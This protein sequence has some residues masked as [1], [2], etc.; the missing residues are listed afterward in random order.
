[1]YSN[2]QIENRKIGEMKN[3]LIRIER[4]IRGKK[5]QEVRF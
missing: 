4:L 5:N 3:S 1:M 2:Q